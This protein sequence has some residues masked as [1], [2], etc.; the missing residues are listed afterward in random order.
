MKWVLV[1]AI[2]YLVGCFSSAYFIGK[3]ARNI[4]IRGYG[5]GNAGTTNAMR[6]MGKKLGILTF[7]LDVLKGIIAVYLGR[8][9]LGDIGGIV[10]GFFA[11]IG[12]DWPLFIGFRGGK[13]VATSLGV[14]LVMSWPSTIIAVIFGV[15]V[16]LL[17]R[18]VSLGSMSFLSSYAIIYVLVDDNFN[19]Q[20]F[21]LA[22]SL[23]ILAI[24]RH[25]SNIQRIVAG[26]ENKLGRW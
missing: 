17:S 15:V 22:L 10:G 13:G 3:L 6:V 5:S 18:F 4:D 20:I 2:S 7:I 19:R 24:I 9:I 1:I 8:L 23:A 14:L 21:I 16:A 25:R 26:N 11:V 12:H